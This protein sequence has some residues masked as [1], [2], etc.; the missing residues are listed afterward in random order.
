MRTVVVVFAGVDE[1][2]VEEWLREV[3]FGKWYVLEG[4]T[5]EVASPDVL[6]G[7]ADQRVVSIA[8]HGQT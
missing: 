4:G 6:V 7:Q 8:S 2:V 1:A 5:T 3:L